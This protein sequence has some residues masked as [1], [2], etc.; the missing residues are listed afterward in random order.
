MFRES[1]RRGICFKGGAE[2]LGLGLGPMEV[3]NK[4]ENGAKR[5][6]TQT[7]DDADAKRRT[8]VAADLWAVRRS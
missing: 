3:L 6:T 7:P 2:G 4:V 1:R 8:A 5:Q